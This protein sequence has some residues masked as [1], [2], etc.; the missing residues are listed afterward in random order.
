MLRLRRTRQ[1][2]GNLVKPREARC[3][4]IVYWLMPPVSVRLCWLGLEFNRTTSA[5]VARHKRGQIVEANP[6]CSTCCLPPLLDGEK[7]VAPKTPSQSAGGKKKQ[8]RK[9]DL[10]RAS[11]AWHIDIEP[12]SGGWSLSSR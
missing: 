2:P 10:R 3:A 12:W 8:E 5:S 11:E 6:P 7:L 1:A 4:G 9:S